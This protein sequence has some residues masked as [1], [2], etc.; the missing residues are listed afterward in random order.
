MTVRN[1]TTIR[2]V[3]VRNVS[4]V[5]TVTVR[6]DYRKKGFFLEPVDFR[7]FLVVAFA[8][9][10]ASRWTIR[11]EGRTIRKE[12]KTKRKEGLLGTKE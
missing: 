6:N 9:S 5:R 8:S 1:G 3:I 4:T 2:T 10:S 12:G 7:R 11:K